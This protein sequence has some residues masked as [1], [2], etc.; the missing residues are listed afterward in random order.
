MREGGNA[1]KKEVAVV[2]SCRELASDLL[3]V[4]GVEE[5]LVGIAL[6]AVERLPI[7]GLEATVDRLLDLT[8]HVLVPFLVQLQD[9]RGSKGVDG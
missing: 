3:G 5:V 8:E 7:H 4:R 9:E 1:H 2:G 6:V